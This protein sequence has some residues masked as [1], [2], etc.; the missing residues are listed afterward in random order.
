M[1][2]FLGS[3]DDA[4]LIQR[5]YVWTQATVYAEDSTV[6]DGCEIEIVKH[7]ATALPYVG[8]AILALTLVVKAIH[9]RNLSTLVITSK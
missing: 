7:L 6:D 1:R 5:S 9:L 2:H 8:V 4:D 3:C